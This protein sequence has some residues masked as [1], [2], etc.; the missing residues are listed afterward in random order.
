MGNGDGVEML[1]RGD[2][3][4]EL[5]AALDDGP[6]AAAAGR[7]AFAEGVVERDEQLMRAWHAQAQRASPVSRVLIWLSRDLYFPRRFAVS[8][9]DAFARA[10]IESGEHDE[11]IA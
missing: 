6:A 1:T 5:D 3:R 7:Q 8:T 4:N 10:I 9:R 2:L 11:R